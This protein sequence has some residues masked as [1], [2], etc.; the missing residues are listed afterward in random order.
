MVSAGGE[1][2]TYTTPSDNDGNSTL[3]FLEVGSGVKSY[4]QPSGVITTEGQSESFTVTATG[5]SEI[6]Y[7]WQISSDNGV[8]W[9]DVQHASPYAGANPK[10][11]TFD[12]IP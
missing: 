11:L 2:F 1:S 6:V 3:D 7:K 4:T 10:T 12:P 5:T 8:T 9:T